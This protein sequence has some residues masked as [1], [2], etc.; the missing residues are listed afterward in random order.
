M[1]EVVVEGVCKSFG[2]T[3][4]LNDL[5]LTAAD[6]DIL[7]LLG[8]SGCGTT[9]VL[10]IISGIVAHDSR[11]VLIGGRG[12]EHLAAGARNLGLVVQSY[13]LFPHLTVAGNV[14]FGLRMR[15]LAKAEIEARI[16]AAL[17]LVDLQN[18][19]ERYTRQL[20]GG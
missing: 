5:S 2:A 7:V 16:G 1:A 12:V 17:K 13:A 3:I 8:P 14:G 6:G 20:S 15:R 4:A 18:L 11:R 19:A 10:R 9:T